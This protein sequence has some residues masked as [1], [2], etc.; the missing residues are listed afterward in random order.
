M[1]EAEV[2]LR[3]QGIDDDKCGVG[4]VRRAC[5]LSDD[6]GGVNG[7]RGIDDASEGLDTTTEA[8]GDRQRARGIYDNK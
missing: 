5:G 4:R 2:S 8:A 7:G 6:D 3:A 1:A